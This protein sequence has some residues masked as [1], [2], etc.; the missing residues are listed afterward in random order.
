MEQ[1]LINFLRKKR[2]VRTFNKYL[3]ENTHRVSGNPSAWWIH[4]D[5]LK[6]K[7]W[8]QAFTAAFTFVNTKEGF[9]YWKRMSEA[10]LQEIE[11]NR[12]QFNSHPYQG[13]K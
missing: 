8:D 13:M 5:Y 4:M 9:N 3:A 11:R 10:W 7:H 12:E 1:L 6:E 2:I